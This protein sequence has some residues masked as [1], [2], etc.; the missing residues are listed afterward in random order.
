VSGQI[1]RRRVAFVEL[2]FSVM[3]Q[4]GQSKRLV[5][6]EI[7]SL[8]RRLESSNCRF[9]RNGVWYSAADARRHLERKLQSAGS[10]RNAEQFVERIASKSSTTGEPYL[11]SC[12]AV[13]P[14]RSRD[15]LL[16]ELRELRAEAQKNAGSMRR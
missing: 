16:S 1:V 8:L 3:G 12:D 6:D 5:I 11:V 7:Q 13:A 9:N 15:W 14:V 10:L 4:A 2:L